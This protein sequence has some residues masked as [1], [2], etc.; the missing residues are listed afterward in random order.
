MPGHSHR[1]GPPYDPELARDL[2]A[3]A[4]HEG[5]RGLPQVELAVPDWLDGAAGE[6][7]EQ[8]KEVLG[9]DVHV[10]VIAWKGPRHHEEVRSSHMWVA[11]WTA[12]YPD[13]DGFFRG[14]FEGESTFYL[15]EELVSL[16]QE[17][18]SVRNQDERMRLYHEVDRLWVAEHAAILP[19]AYGRTLL[20]RRPW[21]EGL[22]ANPLARLHLD[23]VVV[24]RESLV[25]LH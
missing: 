16:V 1:V 24:A 7:L 5:G 18:R 22:W 10:R 23:E 11:G 20:V 15:D 9:V 14:L 17:A 8:W 3:R 19:L 4:G 12:D 25:D 6:L 2:L 13:P 21:V